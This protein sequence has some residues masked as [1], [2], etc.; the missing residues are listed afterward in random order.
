MKII[1]YIIVLSIKIIHATDIQSDVENIL[2][3]EFPQNAT[4]H[5]QKFI[6]PGELKVT[7][8]KQV[9]QK[10]FKDYMHFWKICQDDSIYGY[11]ILDNTYGKSLPITFLV[12]INPAG[13]IRRVDIIR[14]REP[15]GGA[16]GGRSWLDQFSG[17][18]FKDNFQIERGIDS[19]TGATISAKSVTKAVHKILL[20]LEPLISNSSFKCKKNHSKI[21]SAAK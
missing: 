17:K 10:F 16:V 7:A 11:A 3:S 2:K 6:I 8:E 12:I 15:Y 9:H 21:K 18:S 19:I 1:I 13:K 5:H 20:V 14:Y 4:M